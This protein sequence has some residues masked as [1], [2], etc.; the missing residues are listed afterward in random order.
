MSRTIP[1]IEPTIAPSAGTERSQ[2]FAPG[3]KTCAETTRMEGMI[4]SPMPMMKAP[5]SSFSFEISTPSV[6][7]E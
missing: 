4:R 1:R 6:L 5:R 7:N 3:R 2:T